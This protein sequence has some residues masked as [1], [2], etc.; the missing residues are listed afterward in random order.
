MSWSAYWMLIF[1]EIVYSQW[2]YERQHLDNLRLLTDAVYICIDI[3]TIS[4]ENTQYLS[5]L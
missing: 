3:Q 2:E 4:H 5:K 1:I